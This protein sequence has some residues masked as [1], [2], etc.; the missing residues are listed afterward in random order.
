MVTFRKGKNIK[1]YAT[2]ALR[3]PLDSL[4][5]YT[6]YLYCNWSIYCFNSH[7]FTFEKTDPFSLSDVGKISFY[8][9]GKKIQGFWKRKH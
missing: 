4:I 6:L 3:S 9:Y 8:N 1:Q 2:T 5:W 7:L